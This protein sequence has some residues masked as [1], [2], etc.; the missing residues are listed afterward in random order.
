MLETLRT[1]SLGAHSGRNSPAGPGLCTARCYCWLHVEL[2]GRSR[3][4]FSHSAPKEGPSG[5]GSRRKRALGKHRWALAAGAIGTFRGRRTG[6]KPL[7]LCPSQEQVSETGL[8]PMWGPPGMEPGEGVLG[9]TT[10]AS[11]SVAFRERLSEIT[12]SYFPPFL[13]SSLSLGNDKEATPGFGPGENRPLH[14]PG[15]GALKKKRPRG[16]CMV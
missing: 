2:E 9:W 16:S 14:L 8:V 4:P 12:C 13:P 15:R 5:V 3:L 11:A 1:G 6:E 10:R 7:V